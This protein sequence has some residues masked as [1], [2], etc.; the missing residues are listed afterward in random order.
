VTG[1]VAGSKAMI[2]ERN[3]EHVGRKTVLWVASVVML[4]VSVSL[5]VC[6]AVV[7]GSNG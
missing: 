2:C 6:N 7:E 4:T 5:S 1:R 3:K